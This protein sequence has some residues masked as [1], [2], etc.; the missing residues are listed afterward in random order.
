MSFNNW[1][2]IGIRYLWLSINDKFEI[3]LFGIQDFLKIVGS[4]LVQKLFG[5]EI[6][7]VE[8]VGIVF[9]EAHL[10]AFPLCEISLDFHN[11]WDLLLSIIIPVKDLL[12]P[13]DDLSVFLGLHS[14]RRHPLYNSHR[15]QVAGT[16]LAYILQLVVISRRVEPSIE[17]NGQILQSWHLLRCLHIILIVDVGLLTRIIGA[18]NSNDLASKVR[19]S[20]LVALLFILFFFILLGDVDNSTL[21]VFFRIWLTILLIVWLVWPVIWKP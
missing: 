18:V 17:V 13:L 20:L 3:I 14:I 8:D 5:L 1:L 11:F 2:F 12:D 6:I 21:P 15:L 10:L 7:F 16:R 9:K 19:Y 4:P